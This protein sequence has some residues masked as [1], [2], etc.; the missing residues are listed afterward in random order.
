MG[1]QKKGREI[2]GIFLLDKASGLT[3]NRA[4]QAV[5]RVF[6]AKKAGHTGSLDPLATGVLPLCL[7]EATKVS[8]YLLE[9]DKSYRASIKLGQCTDT[10]D[11]DGTVIETV[12][13]FNIT[14]GDVRAAVKR[15]E[16]KIDQTPPMYSAL[17][18]GGT[19]LYKLAR[20]GLVV[21]RQSRQ[22]V[23]HDIELTRCN[24][25]SKEI[26]IIVSCSKGTYIRSIAEDLGR[27][28][29]CGGH[30]TALRRLKAGKFQEASCLTFQELCGILE[31]EGQAGVE[32]CLL[33]TDSAIEHFPQ[34]KLPTETAKW[35][36]NGH[37]VNFNKLPERGLV[38]MYDE[39]IFIGI[40]L[41]DNDG[42][43]A[44]KR[45]MQSVY[46]AMG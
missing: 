41:V 20:K 11:S 38:R 5:K 46:R 12:F 18:V 31:R 1:R 22:V 2:S 13:D 24:L 21:E 10:G 36:L 28:L 4:L 15:F 45:L 26:E 32:E 40:G 7:G 27:M 39:D 43:L 42:K 16:G 33:P 23:I 19:P 30:I 14:E 6:E 29:G 37:A 34:I 25:V 44:P 17:K 9:S 35:V 3:S 8:Q